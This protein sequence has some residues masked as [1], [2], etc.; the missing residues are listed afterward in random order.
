MNP[1]PEEQVVAEPETPMYEDQVFDEPMYEDQEP[2]AQPDV[3]TMNNEQG[4]IMI[5]AMA[6]LQE[7]ANLILQKPEEPSTSFGQG[8]VMINAITHLQETANR[9]LHALEENTSAQKELAH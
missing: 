3:A 5:N 9:I 7:T 2:Y 8:E 6:S 4:E 1:Q